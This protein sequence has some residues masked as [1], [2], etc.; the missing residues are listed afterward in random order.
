MQKSIIFFGTSTTATTNSTTSISTLSESGNLATYS[1]FQ[2]GKT[3]FSRANFI[4]NVGT[5][6]TTAGTLQ[7]SVQER[8]S[9]LGFVETARAGV[10]S[11]TGQYKLGNEPA[12]STQTPNQ[13]GSFPLL[14]NGTDK[15]IVF[16]SNSISTLG[17]DCYFVFYQ[18]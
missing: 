8:F 3:G 17:V 6:T 10:I 9:D 7:V 5:M 13:W 2:F 4:I 11:G 14:G 16:T 12:N 15:Q 1:G 18:D